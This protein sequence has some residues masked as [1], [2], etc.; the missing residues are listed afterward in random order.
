MPQLSL[1]VP[2]KLYKS[3]EKIALIRGTTVEETVIEILRKELDYISSLDS[4]YSHVY[5]K[6]E[7]EALDKLNEAIKGKLVKVRTRNPHLLLKNYIRPFCRFLTVIKEIY[8]K[9]P[10]SIKLSEIRN[11]PDLP[12][13]LYRHV[14]KVKDP[15]GYIDR[16][17]YEKVKSIAP[18]F[19]IEV[20]EE[21]G[22][23]VLKFNN[24]A[25]L[26]GYVGYGSRVLRRRVKR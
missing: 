11:N 7:R 21:G 12:Q 4:H 6:V 5:S 13:I 8:V 26:E 23:V 16:M 17:V 3:L 1:E 24:P 15:V 25:Y 19:K 20:V 9:I 14:G 2:D 18:A 10:H 22:E